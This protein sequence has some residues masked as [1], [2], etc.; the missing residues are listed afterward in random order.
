MPPIFMAQEPQIPSRQDLLKV[1]VGSMSFFI[2]ISASSTIGP[3]LAG[4]KTKETHQQQKPGKRQSYMTTA[5]RNSAP[6]L[7]I[8]EVTNQR[9]SHQTTGMINRR[10]ILTRLDRL[11]RTACEAFHL[12]F[13]GPKTSIQMR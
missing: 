2:L 3:H 12:V 8:S 13:Q 4:S 5:R 9:A 10:G 7:W 11:D 1:S 6:H